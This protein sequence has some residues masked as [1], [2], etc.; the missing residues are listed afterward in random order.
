MSYLDRLEGSVLTNTFTPGPTPQP[1][2]E[3]GAALD[4]I[5]AW[6]TAHQGRDKIVAQF[7][8]LPHSNIDAQ[9]AD[10]TRAHSDRIIDAVLNNK[11]LPEP[12]GDQI[13]HLRDQA[14]ITEAQRGA[15]RSAAAALLPQLADILRAHGDQIMTHLHTR[16]GQIIDQA[17]T[18]GVTPAHI[19]T[20]TGALR[21]GEEQ[22]AALLR[23]E[24]LAGDLAEV[25]NSQKAALGVAELIDTHCFAN[26]AE[27]HP[28]GT[29]APWPGDPAR[30]DAAHLAWLATTSNTHAWVPTS[31][32]HSEAQ[33]RVKDA[34]TRAE[35]NNLRQ[36][37]R[38]KGAPL[39]PS[40]EQRLDQL[41]RK[42]DN[43][44]AEDISPSKN[45]RPRPEV[46]A[47][48]RRRETRARAE[49]HRPVWR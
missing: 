40:Q 31:A 29:D 39:S 30:P 47:A 23:L 32:Q 9:I 24:E 5:P 19:P 26:V 36:A 48:Q 11:P 14:A 16:L 38:R 20:G 18:L 6:V 1:P 46:A 13:T 43:I 49:A 33:Q 4:T 45:Y 42:V 21:L 12:I 44:P 15:L 22:R 35:Y 2:R 41:E 27:L 17:R 7:R 10:L 3:L 28:W 8:A 37:R 34:N 25:R